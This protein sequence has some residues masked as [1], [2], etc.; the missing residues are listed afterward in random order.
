MSL[1]A[2]V[3]YVKT[4]SPVLRPA[5][6]VHRGKRA[7]AVPLELA[8]LFT[9]NNAADDRLAMEKAIQYCAVLY[10]GHVTKADT[11][12]ILDLIS[13]H[14]NSVVFAPPAPKELEFNAQKF[15]EMR[16][17]KIMMGDSEVLN[18]AN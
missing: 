1:S 18:A 5:V 12:R 17:V 10:D 6:V 3:D 11:I 2:F 4:D 15:T 16:G 8:Y 13:H 14:M 7:V 9:G